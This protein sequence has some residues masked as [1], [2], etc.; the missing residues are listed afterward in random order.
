MPESPRKDA[1]KTVIMEIMREAGPG[2]VVSKDELLAEAKRRIPEWFND[3]EP[4]SS[5]CRQGHA[6]KWEHQFQRCLYDLRT[7]IPA[8]IRSADERGTYVLA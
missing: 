2:V 8:K 6:M 4:C 3:S 7:A 5:R 1:F